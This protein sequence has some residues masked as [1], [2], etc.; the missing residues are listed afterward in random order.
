MFPCV[1]AVID[2]LLFGIRFYL[3]NQ[4]LLKMFLDR[5]NRISFRAQGAR[6]NGQR[7]RPHPPSLFELWRDK[8]RAPTEYREEPGPSLT[9]LPSVKTNPGSWMNDRKDAKTQ[10]GVLCFFVSWQSYTCSCPAI[11]IDHPRLLAE[12]VQMRGFQAE[13]LGV[14]NLTATEVPKIGTVDA[15]S[16]PRFP[17]GGKCPAHFS[18]VWKP[19]RRAAPSAFTRSGEM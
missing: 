7:L 15:A 4:Q 14:K 11:R 8:S 2:P 19:S 6:R 1:L 13:R 10:R 16:P 9:L 5:I 3:R 18:E 17:M 12:A